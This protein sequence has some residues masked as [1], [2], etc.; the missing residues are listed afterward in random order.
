[1]SDSTAPLLKNEQLIV[2]PVI[3][4]DPCMQ[5]RFWLA[6]I[7]SRQPPS[8]MI[9][10][11][12][13]NP[14]KPHVVLVGSFADQ[15]HQQLLLSQRQL[16]TLGQASP[17]RHSGPGGVEED[18]FAVPSESSI[19][20]Q[21]DREREEGE[22]KEPPPDNAKTVLRTMREEFGRHFEF[23]EHVFELDCRLSQTA[24]MKALRQ[25]LNVLR[26]RILK[27]NYV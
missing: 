20:G 2:T 12:G 16:P 21:Q 25:Y 18:I 26:S 1:M 9:L 14:N 13:E 10:F 7:K 11:A 6:M 23:H 19:L 27:V 3:I 4:I 15:Q 24:A 8:E 17:L 22:G 5:V